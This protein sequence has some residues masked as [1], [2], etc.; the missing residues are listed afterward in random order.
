[1]NGVPFRMVCG[2]AHAKLRLSVWVLF[3]GWNIFGLNPN[4]SF[5]ACWA[6][7]A[8]SVTLVCISRLFESGITIV[9]SKFAVRS[10]FLSCW[11]LASFF[12]SSSFSYFWN[13]VLSS[14]LASSIMWRYTEV[15]KQPGRLGCQRQIMIRIFSK[16]S[17]RSRKMSFSPAPS[18]PSSSYPSTG[19]YYHNT[20]INKISI[21]S[22]Y[23]LTIC[24]ML[25]LYS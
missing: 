19:F 1:M 22:L 7:N 5:L 2:I 4:R 20:I 11:P 17:F 25:T 12:S 24:G 23:P 15:P 8:F 10:R 6:R 18:S 3:S 9:L 16:A 13:H 14:S 21:L